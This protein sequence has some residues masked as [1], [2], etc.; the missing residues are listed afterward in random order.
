VASA[1]RVWVVAQLAAGGTAVISGG[2]VTRSFEPAD[3]LGAAALIDPTGE[4]VIR[5]SRGAMTLW[6]RATGDE[7]VWNLD[8]MKLGVTAQIL[9]DGRIVLAGVRVGVLDIARDPRPVARLLADIACHVPLKVV[10]SRLEP[11][12]TVCD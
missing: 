11:S 1:D 9:E 8:L 6:E 10:G 7:L 4:L 5:P 3:A 2:E 12:P